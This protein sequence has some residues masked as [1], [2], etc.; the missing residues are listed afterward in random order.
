MALT[1]TV[2]Y[3]I[4]KPQRQSFEI[5][6]GGITGNI[7]SP[8][9]AATEVALSDLRSGRAQ[10]SFATDGV[11]FKVQP[12]AVD[13]FENDDSWREV[14]DA[15]LV[16]LLRQELDAREVIVFDHTLR[17]DD[18]EASRCPARNVHSD[19]SRQGAEARLV[20]LLGKDRASAWAEGHY[21][22]INVW[23]PVAAPINSAPLGFVRPSSVAA[24][25]W[26]LLDL[27]YPGRVG[28]IMG[29]AANPAHD[30]VYQS[31]MTPEE[32][33]YFNIYDNRD[34]PSVAHSAIDLVENPSVSAVRKSLESRTLI[35][36]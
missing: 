12:T 30:W 22:F 36:F 13:R 3:L 24:E 18:P 14:Y 11:A 7:V 25:D 23:R 4:H 33:V 1:G 27:I 15:E 20:S 29:L 28:S 9:M 2:N 5:D 10:V 21:A 26:I 17:V 16:A 32:I 35:R 34:R 8:E 19:Y 6:A 31:R